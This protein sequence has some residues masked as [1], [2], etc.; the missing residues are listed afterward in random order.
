MTSLHEPAAE[1]ATAR[2]VA[3]DFVRAQLAFEQVL[4]TSDLRDPLVFY[5]L[6]DV[7][8]AAQAFAE[9]VLATSGVVID[10]SSELHVAISELSRLANI[11]VLAFMQVPPTRVVHSGRAAAAVVS[12]LLDAVVGDGFSPQGKP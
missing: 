7:A 8:L 1:L 9:Q 3:E 6:R 2:S 5:R 11:H 12:A 4:A 10:P